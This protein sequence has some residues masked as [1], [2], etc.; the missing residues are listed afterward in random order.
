MEKLKLLCTVDGNVNGA[1]ALENSLAGPQKL[2]TELPYNP[3]ISCLRIY[4]KE[5]KA[6]IQTNTCT[7]IFIALFTIAKRWKQPKYP[8]TNEWINK[9]RSIH[10][11]EYYPAL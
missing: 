4:S 9:M 2:N 11:T 10:T 8:T 1:A 3:A 7:Q 6:D 5:L